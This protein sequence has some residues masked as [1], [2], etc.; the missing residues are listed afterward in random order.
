MEIFELGAG[1]FQISVVIEQLQPSQ[2]LLR[3]AAQKG[4]GGLTG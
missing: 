3:T 2:K 1:A 4:D